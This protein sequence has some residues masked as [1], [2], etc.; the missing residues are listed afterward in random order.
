MSKKH[1]I[2]KIEKSALKMTNIGM[3]ISA[4]LAKIKNSINMTCVAIY[5][6][7]T[8]GNTQQ[9]YTSLPINL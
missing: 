7:P 4:T 9:I 3:K 8:P 2:N 6:K 5:V 1:I